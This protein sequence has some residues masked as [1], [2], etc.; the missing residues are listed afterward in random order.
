[1][2]SRPRERYSDAVH[3]TT[4]RCQKQLTYEMWHQH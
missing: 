1:V 3:L 4:A 2:T